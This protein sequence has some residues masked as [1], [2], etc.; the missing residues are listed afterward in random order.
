LKDPKR[1]YDHPEARAE[2][3]MDAFKDTSIKAIFST[4]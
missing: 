2:D 1:I 4:I 3:L